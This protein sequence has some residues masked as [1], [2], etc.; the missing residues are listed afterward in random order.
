MHGL[1][2]S[3]A[4]DE[5]R[6]IL[7]RDGRLFVSVALAMMVLPTVIASLIMPEAIA[8]SGNLVWSSLIQIVAYMIL[9]AGQLALIRLALGPSITVG[10]AIGHGIRR[11]PIYFLSVCIL[12]AL[13]FVLAVPFALLL[14]VAGVPIDPSGKLPMTAPVVI[15]V[16]IYLLLLTFMFVRMGMATAVASAEDCNALEIVTRSWKL[17]A[18]RF[19]RLF[20]FLILFFVAASLVSFGIAA[21]IGV[22]VKLFIGSVEPMSVGGLLII[23]VRA[24]LN[25]AVMTLLTVMIAR[26]YVQLSGHAETGSG[27]PITG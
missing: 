17:T 15:S 9:L 11:A 5:T 26:I 19:W 12:V 27:V 20:L 3:R 2:I 23:L 7:S 16:C 18:G 10:G 8:G 14:M 22:L 24:L 4:W 13:L 1:S 21:V 6:A 25:A